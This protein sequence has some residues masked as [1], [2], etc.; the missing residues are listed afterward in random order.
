MTYD[1]LSTAIRLRGRGPRGLLI[2]TLYR[3]HALAEAHVRLHPTGIELTVTADGGPLWSQVFSRTAVE[4]FLER[5]SEARRAALLNDDWLPIGWRR[6]RTV[7]QVKGLRSRSQPRAERPT[8]QE[9]R[10]D[11]DGEYGKRRSARSGCL[12]MGESCG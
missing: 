11:P 12:E 5:T 9:A 1:A 4:M 7:P 6:P 2:W 10:F 3:D 8:A